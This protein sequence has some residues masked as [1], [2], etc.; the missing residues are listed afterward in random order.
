LFSATVEDLEKE[1]LEIY[2]PTV[3]GIDQTDTVEDSKR[4]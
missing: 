2:V 4:N 1:R 3:P